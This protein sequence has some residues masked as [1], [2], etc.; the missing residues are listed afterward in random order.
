VEIEKAQ[1]II[2]VYASMLH[3]AEATGFALAIRIP[4]GIGRGWKQMLIKT[5]IE[6]VTKGL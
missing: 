5:I 6:P 3:G 4:L 2:D 1:N